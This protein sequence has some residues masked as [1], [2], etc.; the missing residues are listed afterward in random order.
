MKKFRLGFGFFVLLFICVLTQQ[1]FLLLNYMLALFLHEMAHLVVAILRGYH[2]KEF[3]LDLFGMS[4][5]LDTDINSRDVFLINVAGPAFNLFVCLVCMAVYWLVP[6]SFAILND[7]CMSNLVLCLFNIL[8]V[9]P[10]DGGKIFRGMIKKDKVYFGLDLAFRG[11]CFALF[12]GLFIWSSLHTVNWFFALFACFFII[13][14]PSKKV[15][16]SLFKSAKDKSFEKVVL[17]KVEE[18]DNLYALIKHINKT[19]YTI[20]YYNQNKPTY[21]DEDRVVS[22]ALKYPLTTKLKDIK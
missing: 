7:F 2:L 15:T 21:I 18:S 11:C 16:L 20:F 17:L 10:L 3:K 5:E 13:S 12:A 1:F 6:N 14:K 4:V 22:L 9:Q 19:R 8:P